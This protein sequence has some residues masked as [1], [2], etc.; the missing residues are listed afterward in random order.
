[1]SNYNIVFN[2]YELNKLNNITEY[3]C[4]R[5]KIMSVY[6]YL[7]K[8]SD[9]GHVVKSIPKLHFTFSRYTKGISLTYFKQIIKLL[10]E[11]GLLV[12]EKIGRTNSINILR[13]PGKAVPNKVPNKNTP[14]AIENK[15]FDEYF[16]K[17]K[18][19]NN[20]NNI[21]NTLSY[22]NEFATKKELE[23]IA[24]ELFKQF[25][26][27]SRHVKVDVMD[28][29]YYYQDRINRLGARQ[30]IARIIG[31]KKAKRNRERYA[32]YKH[33][34]LGQADYNNNFIGGQQSEYMQTNAKLIEELDQSN[35]DDYM[36]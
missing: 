36:F 15:G 3:M 20:N 9:N 34:I 32:Y 29:I 11:V 24:N 16:E 12:V 2:D 27:R 30:Y 6:Q 33:F 5:K 21:N 22:M 7:I 4:K 17:H 14:Q 8:Y 25:K 1:M 35:I 26:V 28:K 10:K 18:Y 19:N 23:D 31:E 13:T